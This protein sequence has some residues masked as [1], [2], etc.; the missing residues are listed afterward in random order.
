MHALHFGKFSNLAS[1]MPATKGEVPV[2]KSELLAPEENWVQRNLISPAN[3][4][5]IADIYSPVKN[6]VNA[7][8]VPLLQKK[9]LPEAS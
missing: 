9:L 8:S 5:L 2:D 1:N 7:I 6:V 4:A 3:E